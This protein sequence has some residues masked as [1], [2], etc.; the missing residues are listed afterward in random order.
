MTAEQKKIVLIG[1]AGLLG[2]V[3]LYLVLRK[4]GA[5]TTALAPLSV[6]AAGNIS[7]SFPTPTAPA[8]CTT[9]CPSCDDVASSGYAAQLP[10]PGGGDSAWWDW[11]MR[12][13][14]TGRGASAG[15]ASI[16][17]AASAYLPG[18]DY[19]PNPAGIGGY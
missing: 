1:G 2:V 18:G 17:A 10:L 13:F 19:L 3:I 5:G 8:G 14:D 12:R 4:K 11:E 7:Y 16:S 15:P 6:P 9:V